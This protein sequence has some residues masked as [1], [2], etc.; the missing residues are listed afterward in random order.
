MS[1]CSLAER[2]HDVTV[3]MRTEASIGTAVCGG[4]L[5]D[6]ND[7]VGPRPEDKPLRIEFIGDSINE[8]ISFLEK[9]VL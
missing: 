5:V 8:L 7:V 1:A 9:T 6:A 4:F 3:F 2:K